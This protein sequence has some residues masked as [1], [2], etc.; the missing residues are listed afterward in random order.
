[1]YDNCEHCGQAFF[2]EPGFYYGA[3]YISYMFFAFFSLGF[4]AVAHWVLGYST[5]VSIIMLMVIGAIFFVYIFRLARS[6]YLTMNV[7][8]EPKYDK[9]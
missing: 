2:P 8:Y 9:Q 5:G 3:M 7:A 4:V 1:M 6:I